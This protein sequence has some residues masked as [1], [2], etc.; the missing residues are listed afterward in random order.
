MP[1]SHPGSTA[2][3]CCM[4]SC[5]WRWLGNCSWYRMLPPVC[6]GVWQ[7]INMLLLF[8]WITP[9]AFWAQIKVLVLTYKALSLYCLVSVYLKA[10]HT[11]SSWEGFLSVL[12]WS[13]ARLVGTRRGPSPPLCTCSGT[14]TLCMSTKSHL[15]RPL[16]RVWNHFFLGMP[17]FIVL[18]YLWF[19]LC[20]CLFVLNC[21]YYFYGF[22]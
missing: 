22:R 12:W 20:F 4:W 16:G 5:L 6:W 13:E 14:P 19:F 3:M 8:G 7:D 11:L 9:A 17:W 21:F 2:V 10:H 18:S 1:W 15:F